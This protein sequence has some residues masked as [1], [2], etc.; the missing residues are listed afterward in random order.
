VIRKLFRRSA[1]DTA[2]MIHHQEWRLCGTAAVS[3]I[4]RV[5]DDSP[6]DGGGATQ[7]PISGRVDQLLV[8]MVIPEKL[9]SP[10]AFSH[11]NRTRP[12]HT[13][14]RH[15]DPTILGREANKLSAGLSRL[16]VQGKASD[17]LFSPLRHVS[18]LEDNKSGPDNQIEELSQTELH[19]ESF[20]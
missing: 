17:D 5:A 7:M 14:M 19:N 6:G 13:K 12:K 4:L 8:K 1:R 2:L 20:G 9:S 10:A 3:S 15:G 11:T 16:R 18:F